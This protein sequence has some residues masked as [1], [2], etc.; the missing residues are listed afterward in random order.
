VCEAPRAELFAHLDAAN[1]D[2]KAF[3]EEFYKQTCGGH[4]QAVLDTIEYAVRET[5]VWVELTTLLIP[6]LNDSPAEIDAMT[7]WIA[8][9]LGPD[10]PLHFSAFHPDFRMLDIERTPP[11][12]LTR[13]RNIAKGN[14]LHHVYVGNV[15][16]P[17]GS[18]TFCSGCGRLV[19]ERDWYRLGAYHLDDQGRCRYCGTRCPGRFDGPPGTWGPRRQPVSFTGARRR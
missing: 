7:R 15:H 4:L 11:A 12:T 19:I 18:S 8:E 5:D 1:I 14:D 10:V 3:T 2:L 17:D 6:G 13:A 16:D 9:R